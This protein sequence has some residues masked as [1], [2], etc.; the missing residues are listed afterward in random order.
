METDIG[1]LIIELVIGFVIS[2]IAVILYNIFI[3]I[4]ILGAIIVA[5]MVVFPKD[6]SEVRGL[7][8]KGVKDIRGRYSFGKNTILRVVGTILI[9]MSLNLAMGD[10]AAIPILVGTLIYALS[11]PSTLSDLKRQMI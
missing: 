1:K 8:T 10:E 7:F 11:S 5:L 6:Y 3:Y 2:I 4:L 9:V